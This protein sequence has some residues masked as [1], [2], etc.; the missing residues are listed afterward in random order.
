M[1]ID[2]SVDPRTHLKRLIEHEDLAILSV[3]NRQ[4]LKKAMDRKR[5]YVYELKKIRGGRNGKRRQKCFYF[6]KFR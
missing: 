3:N 6:R 1:E 5:K 4:G 2:N